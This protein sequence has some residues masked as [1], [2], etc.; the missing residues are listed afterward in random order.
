MRLAK[1]VKPPNFQNIMTTSLL[2]TVRELIDA[3]LAPHAANIDQQGLYPQPFIE[4]LAQTGALSLLS[5]DYAS[6]FAQNAVLSEIGATCGTTAF[7]LWC[8]C[9][10]IWYLQ[11]S[12]NPAL[13]ARYLKQAQ[14]GKRYGATGLSNTIKSL[15]GI[16]QHRLRAKPDGDGYRIDGTLAWVSHVKIGHSLAITAQQDDGSLIMFIADIDGN[17]VRLSDCPPFTGLQGSLTA[18]VQFNNHYLSPEYLLVNPNQTHDYLKKITLGMVS[19]QL[20]IAAGITQHALRLINT[21]NQ[22]NQELNQYLAE[23]YQYETLNN[24]YLA[25]QQSYQSLSKS[26]SLPALLRVLELRHAIAIL[27]LDTAQSASIHAGGLGY[28]A[29]HPASRL[30]REAAFIAVV[31][32]TLKHLS[33]EIQRQKQAA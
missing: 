13:K 17:S 28:L 29:D 19:L 12:D 32:P 8:H 25:W 15:S 3:Q 21:S 24:R 23:N 27:A 20:G 5:Q 10:F 4:A 1:I 33:R 16:E 6:I 18:Q 22:F 26:A 31:T 14:T 30:L 7:T 9:A 11:Q 2:H